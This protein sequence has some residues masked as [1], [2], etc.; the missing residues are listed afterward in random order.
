AAGTGNDK[1]TERY[2][3]L[4]LSYD[5]AK[6]PA[7]LLTLTGQD[8][9]HLRA[10]VSEFGPVLL[11]KILGLNNTQVGIVALIFKYC[12]DHALPLLDLKD[13]IKML[14]YV[15]AEGK[16]EIEK[17]YG[18]VSTTATGTILR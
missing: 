6:Y 15:G 11:S 7:E 1:L 8:G 14:Q 10:T 16:E 13:F 18:K 2:Q 4:Q 5:P 17:V 3:K 12:D 9:V